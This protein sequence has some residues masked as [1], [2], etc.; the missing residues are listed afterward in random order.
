MVVLYLFSNGTP[1]AGVSPRTPLCNCVANK[2]SFH[3]S[4]ILILTLCTRASREEGIFPSPTHLPYCR[5]DFYFPNLFLYRTNILFLPG[6]MLC[7][8][9]AFLL[10]VMFSTHCSGGQG[11]GWPLLPSHPS[12]NIFKFVLHF[13]PLL[14][15]MSNH[16]RF[17]ENATN[18]HATK[19]LFSTRLDTK[20]LIL[21]PDQMRENLYVPPLAENTCYTRRL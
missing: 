7:C 20:T 13:H 2:Q 21:A 1:D 11:H 5:A 16:A 9:F 6:L 10:T 4:A 18:Y 3:P 12:S 15:W 17:F 19:V 8:L 14:L